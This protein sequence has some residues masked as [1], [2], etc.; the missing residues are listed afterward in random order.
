MFKTFLAIILCA[1][2]VSATAYVTK[3]PYDPNVRSTCRDGT[4]S[5]SSGSG[6]CSN[7]GGVW[8]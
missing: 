5:S 6:A 4:Y 8:R 2:S 7:H 1:A 3:N